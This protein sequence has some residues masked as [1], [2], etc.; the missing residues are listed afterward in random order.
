[1]QMQMQK[2]IQQ[3]EA[4]LSRENEAGK[5]HRRRQMEAGFYFVPG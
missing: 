1:M 5:E 3:K 2:Q 4:E